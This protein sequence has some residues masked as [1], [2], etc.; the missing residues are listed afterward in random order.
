MMQSSAAPYGSASGS[1]LDV[2]VVVPTSSSASSDAPS[3]STHRD[4]PQC[5]PN[6]T[7][8]NNGVVASSDF[9]V[10][11]PSSLA[12]SPS[13]LSLRK[14]DSF[15]K[16]IS[17]QSSSLRSL[18]FYSKSMSNLSNSSS[19]GNG[20][21]SGGYRT[22]SGGSDI[23]HEDEEQEVIE[24]GIEIGGG[25]DN[26]METL[27]E[28]GTSCTEPH[29]IDDYEYRPMQQALP[30]SREQQKQY[31]DINNKSNQTKR[32]G[33]I[34]VQIN[35]RYIPQ[36]DMTFSSNGNGSSEPNCRF[37]NG[38]GIRPSTDTLNMLVYDDRND[39]QEEQQQRIAPAPMCTCSEAIRNSE[40]HL[41]NIVPQQYLNGNQTQQVNDSSNNSHLQTSTATAQRTKTKAILNRGRNLIRYNLYSK[42]G[43][44][45]ATA[46]AH[47]YL[48]SSNNSIIVS[49][50]DGTVTKSDV[51]G[52]IDTVIQDKFEYCHQGICKLFHEMLVMNT[53]NKNDTDFAEEDDIDN[54]NNE[55][56]SKLQTTQPS[57]GAE[58]GGGDQVQ[59]IYLT[60][61]PISL[62]SQT[63]KLLVSLS[64]PCPEKGDLYGLPPGPTL[65]HTGPLSSVLYS[66]LVAKNIHE[67]KADVLVRQVVLPFVAARGDVA[68]QNNTA[69]NIDIDVPLRSS[70][71]LSEA[72]SFWGD[73][74]RLFVAG[75]GNKLTDAMAYEMAGIDRRDIYIIDK[76]SRIL[77]MDGTAEEGSTDDE[78]RMSSKSEPANMSITNSE[79]SLDEVCCPGVIDRQ[80][81]SELPVPPPSQ[82]FNN[83]S[84]ATSIQ[85]IELSLTEEQKQDGQTSSSESVTMSRTA[86]DIFSVT[87]DKS[88]GNSSTATGKRAKLKQSIRAFSSKKS[89]RKFPSFGSTTNNV[90]K[91]STKK[92]F[93]GYDDPLLLTRVRERMITS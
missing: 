76:E 85:S 11:F 3:S 23:I 25:D 62:I 51:R 50:I 82:A 77:C 87:N 92:L 10:T 83:S 75:F 28:R 16:S 35:G 65:C 66:E 43:Q 47:I 13:T 67:F 29:H 36:L 53:S 93:K 52:V 56:S 88:H 74:D 60:A 68:L 7:N 24:E 46:E 57:R 33:N 48:W 44:I 86:V 59:F 69:D 73:D 39:D 32:K 58:G 78:R 9:F 81:L 34:Q 49:D 54:N 61:R 30:Q 6:S 89:F 64:Q 20:N 84:V 41:C 8:T 79:W 14:K 15:R 38:N 19:N 1:A 42:K 45:V 22:S 55:E 71:G 18:L 12:W 27:S 31:I 37:V 40:H 21:G 5:Q 91:Q 70:S 17:K 72:S 26:D 63:R 80:L 4:A 2:I 90:K